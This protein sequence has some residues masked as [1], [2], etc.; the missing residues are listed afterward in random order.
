VLD[1]EADVGA[2]AVPQ[3]RSRIRT[4]GDRFAHEREQI[5]HAALG[6]RL[7]Q[8][9]P[10]GEVVIGRVVAHVRGARDLSQ[11]DLLRGLL[12]EQLHRRVLERTREVAVVIPGP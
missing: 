1:R 9:V 2:A 12:R 8:T 10:I 5:R 6:D 4:R 3:R 11:A 7:D